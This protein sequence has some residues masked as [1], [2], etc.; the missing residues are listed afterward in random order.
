MKHQHWRKSLAW[1]MA[2]LALVAAVTACSGGD[3]ASSPSPGTAV[4]S[5]TAPDAAE[6]EGAAESSPSPEVRTESG[7][8]VGMMDGHTIEITVNGQAMAFQINAET[9]EKVSTWEEG[10]QVK[11][12]YQEHT[13][14]V[15]GEQVKQYSITAID[16]A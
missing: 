11:F 5:Q 10:T 1:S 4:P 15:N 16:K 8:Y 9:A 7:E 13:L 6:T 3:N 2:S 14:D 12:Q